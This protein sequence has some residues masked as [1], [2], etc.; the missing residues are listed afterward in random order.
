[1]TV[2]F[3]VPAT[4]ESCL[5][6]GPLTV[7]R[8]AAPV[9]GSEDLRGVLAAATASRGRSDGP[10]LL[11]SRCRATAAFSRR[12]TLSPGY[13][14]ARAAA[15][16]HGFEPV[17]RPVGGHLAGYDESSLVLHLWGP[18]DDPRLD[19][20][21]RFGVVSQAI[22][23]ALG[24]LSVPDV[25][26]GAVPGEYCDG[27]WSVNVGGDA[28]VA[29]LGQRLLRGGFLLCAVLT[30][31]RPR[32]LTRMLVDSYAAL[33]LPLDPATVGAVDTWVP[34]VTVEQVGESVAGALARQLP[35]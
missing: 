34:G 30:V 11:L 14:Q 19:L 23:S 15:R 7:L 4:G 29:G 27:A 13:A 22:A 10:V 33:G 12:D 16:D 8:R 35:G 28:K 1:M 20:R 31:S 25:R 32:P 6:S 2:S 5:G 9:S 18:R 17:V 3:A 24:T 26:V 21:Q